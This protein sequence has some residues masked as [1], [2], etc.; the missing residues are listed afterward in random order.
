MSHSEEKG[1]WVDEDP[2]EKL[3]RRPVRRGQPDAA[4]EYRFLFVLSSPIREAPMKS[5]RS[6]QSCP[7]MEGQS[8]D[9]AGRGLLPQERNY[10]QEERF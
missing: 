1:Q 6:L 7:T 9:A 2:K 5:A 3:L 10:A 4:V 8:L